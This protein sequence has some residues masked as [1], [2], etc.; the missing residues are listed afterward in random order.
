FG[1][2]TW[3]TRLV[4]LGLP[5]KKQASEPPG[6]EMVNCY[7]PWQTCSINELGD[8]KPCCVYWRSMGNMSRGGFA[9]VWNGRKY[10]RLRRRVNA[11]SSD[12]IC[13]ACRLPRFDSEENSSANLLKPGVRQL[14]K[15]IFT[16]P[17]PHAVNHAGVMEE[18]FDPTAP[19][20]SAATNG[21]VL[22]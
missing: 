6:I 19:P 8:V 3:D 5:G 12:K 17:P 7:H 20:A 4:Q 21:T 18:E 16:R 2:G 14:V 15:A 1:V 22:V 10:R 13:Y 9:S 11:K